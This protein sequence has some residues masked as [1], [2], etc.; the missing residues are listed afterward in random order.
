MPW[1]AILMPQVAIQMP[2]VATRM[3]QVATWMPQV[4]TWMSRTIQGLYTND[5]AHIRQGYV[6]NSRVTNIHG[7]P[8]IEH[9]HENL[10][11]STLTIQYH[12]SQ[13]K[14]LMR[15]PFNKAIYTTSDASSSCI[16]TFSAIFTKVWLMD[17]RM[18]QWTNG[19]THSL[20]E[21]RGRI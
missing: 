13:M 14:N 10:S 3:P 11:F 21:M 4:G 7:E 12:F 5:T 19:Q 18:D 1:L 17:Q 9:V 16:T 15:T 20:I 8:K 2:W 6:Y